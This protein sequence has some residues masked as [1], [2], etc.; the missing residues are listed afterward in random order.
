MSDIKTPEVKNILQS[1]VEIPD[2][3]KRFNEDRIEKVNESEN[4]LL[5]KKNNEIKSLV[6]SGKNLLLD[7]K[8]KSYRIEDK[9]I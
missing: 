3:D 4:K 8:R 5:F 7:M 1:E 6:Y 2:F 9:K